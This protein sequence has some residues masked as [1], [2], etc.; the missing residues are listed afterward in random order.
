MLVAMAQECLGGPA[1]RALLLSF[2]QGGRVLLDCGATPRLRQHTSTVGGEHAH[3]IGGEPAAPQPCSAAGQRVGPSGAQAEASRQAPVAADGTPDEAAAPPA[4]PA[5]ASVGAALELEVGPLL[6]RLADRP[7]DALLVSSPQGL[8]GLPHLWEQQLM[9]PCVYATVACLNLAHAWASELAHTA[10]QLQHD[11][12]QREGAAASAQ[13]PLLQQSLAVQHKWART[14]VHAGNAAES[15]SAEGGARD[16]ECTP[17]FDHEQLQAAL[18]AVTA[19]RYGQRVKLFEGSGGQEVVATAVPS[20]CGM[21]GT[22]WLLAAGG[23][24]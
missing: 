6:G 5:A 22:C 2:E 12:W 24:E 21:G 15:G 8:L 1:S 17:M 16:A 7:A 20:G 10:Q 11:Q 19:V 13:P 14:H 18:Q 4:L 3:S 23:R 9:P